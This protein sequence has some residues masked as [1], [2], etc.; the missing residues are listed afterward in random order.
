M[1]KPRSEDPGS[2]RDWPPSPEPRR[3]LRSSSVNPEVVRSLPLK[4]KE[5]LDGQ[6]AEAK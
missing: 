3:K 2:K 5:R 4:L 1:Q 6:K